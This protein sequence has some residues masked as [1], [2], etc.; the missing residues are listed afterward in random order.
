M[1][2][3]RVISSTDWVADSATLLKLYRCL[4][5]SKLGYGCIVYGSARKS[6]LNTLDRVQ[7]SALRICLGAFRK[8]PT[9]S[10]HVEAGEMPLNLR[11]EKFTFQ[12]VLELKLNPSNPSYDYI[13]KPILTSNF[14]VK[15]SLIPPLIYGIKPN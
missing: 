8:L 11:R 1:N 6:Y 13:F 10:L 3:L 7:N 5:R 12:Y 4:I 15:P 2:L 9:A 14:Y